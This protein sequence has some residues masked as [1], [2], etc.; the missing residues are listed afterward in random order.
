MIKCKLRGIA[1]YRS[2]IK[3]NY[4]FKSRLEADYARYL[5]FNNIEYEYEVTTFALK[6]DNKRRYYTPDFYLIKEDKFIDLKC[7]KE[8]IHL[9]NNIE[10]I[11]LLIKSLVNSVVLS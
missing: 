2:D 6:I 4:R 9:Y 8:K 10:K 7:A 5:E 11:D 3:G 1:G